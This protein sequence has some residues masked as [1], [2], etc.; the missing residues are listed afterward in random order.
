MRYLICY[1]SPDTRRRN[2]VARLLEGRGFRVQW[3]VFECQLSPA[4]F[5][6]LRRAIAEVIDPSEDSVRVYPLCETC[7]GSIRSIG[8]SEPYGLERDAFLF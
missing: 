8:L 1:D 5:V 7:A 6:E 3:S 4:L 2:Q